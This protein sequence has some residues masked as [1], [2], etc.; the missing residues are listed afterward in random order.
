[1]LTV[2]LYQ[3][4]G[5]GAGWSGGP[6]S[7]GGW[8]LEREMVPETGSLPTPAEQKCGS[9]QLP[10]PHPTPSTIWCSHPSSPHAPNPRAEEG[11]PRT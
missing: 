7:S 8:S 9:L 3:D 10:G 11:C 4:G 2:K 1:M 5:N 6:S